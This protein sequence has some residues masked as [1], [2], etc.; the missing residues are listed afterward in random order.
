MA[1]LYIKVTGD[2]NTLLTNTETDFTTFREKNSLG[3]AI[4]KL[5]YSRPILNNI[6]QTVYQF[7]EEDYFLRN[8]IER[9]DNNSLYLIYDCVF[10]QFHMNQNSD[11]VRKMFL[12]LFNARSDEDVYII[13]QKKISLMTFKEKEK[14]K[15][16]AL[17]D[18]KI[19][20][21]MLISLQGQSL[22]ASIGKKY[23]LVFCKKARDKA[24]GFGFT[25][26]KLIQELGTKIL[27]CSY[28]CDDRI[29]L[30]RTFLQY[31]FDEL[32]TNKIYYDQQ[33]LTK[34]LKS[35]VYK[36]NRLRFNPYNICFLLDI[37]KFYTKTE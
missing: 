8:Q 36:I 12:V 34:Q 3:M 13:D 6:N 25:N 29:K 5:C 30:F 14:I 37:T 16:D 21:N 1:T 32:A 18:Q 17:I 15:Y 11:E 28:S 19:N 20:N 26:E 31:F 4:Y 2:N 10:Q 33:D 27:M 35:T 22:I 24:Q 9:L 23:E 7:D